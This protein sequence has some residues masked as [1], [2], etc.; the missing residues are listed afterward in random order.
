MQ[1]GPS[2]LPHAAVVSPRSSTRIVPALVALLVACGPPESPDLPDLGACHAFGVDEPSPVPDECPIE[3]ADD[4][5]SVRVFSVGAVVRY[6]QMTDYAA[7]CRTWDD[8]VR[9]QVVPCLATDRPN[10]VVFPENATLAAAFIGS[11]GASS[12]EADETLAGFFPFFETYAQPF[13]FYERRHPE[14]ALNEILFLALSDTFHRAYQT[15]P[16]IA[17]TYGVHVVLS[18]DLAPAASIDDPEIIEALADPDLEDVASVWVATEPATYNFGIWI[19]PDGEEIARVPKT[20]LTPDEE[21]LLGLTHGPLREVRPVDLGFARTGM[22][23]SKDAWMPD[24]LARLDAWGVDV[25]LQPEAF[26]GWGVEQYEDD[27]L[28]DVFKQSSWAHVQRHAAFRYNITP[29]IKGNLLSLPFDCQSHIVKDA[30]SSDA[31]MG[32][33]GQVP[34]QGWL[35]VEPWVMPEPEGS[36]ET[37]RAALRL[38]GHQMLPGSG[39]ALEDAYTNRVIAADLDLN[40]DGIHRVL[41]DGAPGAW[42]T[43]AL[44]LDPAGS[45]DDDHVVHQ[46]HPSIAAD[47]Q[48]VVVA[49]AEGGRSGGTIRLARS[50]DAGATFAEVAVPEGP[51]GAAARLPAVAISGDRILVAFEE[52][53]ESGAFERVVALVSVDGGGTWQRQP[54]AGTREAP[55]WAPDVA[56]DAVTGRLHVAWLDLRHGGRAKPHLASS[57]DGTAWTD[58][59]VDPTNAVI[60]NPRGNAAQVQVAAADAVVHV[61][62]NDFRA[63]AW[64]L[65]LV[66]STDGG[67]SFAQAERINPPARFSRPSPTGSEVELE[68]LHADLQLVL[69]AD[70]VP[71]I[72]HGDLQDRRPETR[73]AVVRAGESIRVDDAPPWRDAWRPTIAAR[74]DGTWVLAWQDHRT[75]ANHIRTAVRAPGGT[76]EPSLVVDDSAAEAQTFRPRIALVGAAETPVITWED[77]RFGPARVRLVRSP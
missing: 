57:D 49:F 73:V 28:P 20:Y 35:A 59:W 14:L 41:G 40:P 27:W 60:G 75:G 17:R 13:S 42:G 19:N 18:T 10:L 31:L 69:D 1:G 25:M 37:R 22:V 63:A 61:A 48:N 74:R 43:S 7:F 45:S 36:L 15:F 16:A 46:R 70:G 62:F 4:G 54:I 23:I 6:A 76:S 72:A 24:V 51:A 29:C 9:A 38:R 26:S 21:G 53:D 5:E 3:I 8:V 56:I 44:V 50:S 67:D 77:Y 52:V 39:D 2:S 32:F 64:D 33:I 34:V 65:Y 12:R 55:G 11:R 30:Q 66:S 47:D 68:R 71:L 58:V